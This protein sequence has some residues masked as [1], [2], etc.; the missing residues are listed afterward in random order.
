MKKKKP[1]GTTLVLDAGDFLMGTLFQDLEPETGFQLPLMKKM[2]YD[3]VCIGNHEFDFGPEK[4]A[5]II[6]FIIE[7]AR[8]LTCF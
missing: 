4:L 3:V 7:M 6:F 2:G 1:E 5:E 8:Y